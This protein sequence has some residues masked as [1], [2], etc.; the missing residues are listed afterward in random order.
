[1]TKLEVANRALSILTSG[2]IT[3][4]D[5]ALDE[6][7]RSIKAIFDI[8]AREVMR[9]HRW[10]CCIKRAE[11]T[12]SETSPT[13]VG[14]FGYQFSYPLPTDC[15]RFLD[16][17]GE[18]YR[19]K[20]EFMDLNG[21]DLLSN[22]GTAHIRYVADMTADADVLLWDVSMAAAISVKIAMMVG[23]RIT[24]DGMS[25]EELYQLYQ[26]ELDTARRLDAMEM[27]SGENRPIER[28]IENS[29]LINHGRRVGR[30]L[31]QIIGSE[32]DPN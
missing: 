6:K 4:L 30:N 17:N 21:R 5:D 7:A 15:L 20:S 10:S 23:R 24:K 22:A 26:R 25:Y 18:P 27:G 28:I 11:L 12:A 13:K 19:P 3:D 2:T 32:V 29:P 1:M 16:L 8:A 31:N 9:E 14:Y